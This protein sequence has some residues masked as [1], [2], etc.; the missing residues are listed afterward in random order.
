M[1]HPY[2]SAAYAEV[3]REAA[4]PLWVPAWGAHVL[5]RDIAGGGRDAMG[6]YPLTAFGPGADLRAGLDMLR[7]QGL[8]SVGLVPDPATA[9]VDIE[10]V[11]GLCVPFKTHLLVDYG[12]EVRFSKHHRYE[13]KKALRDVSVQTVTLV[14]HLD[15][16]RGLYAALTERH[17]IGGM[18]AFSP[19]AFERMAEVENLTAVAA[20]AEGAIVSMHLWITDPASGH[21]YSLL[22]A[23][24]AEG[25]RRSAAYAVYDA[26]IRLFA[27]LKTLNLGAGAGLATDDDG[28]TRFKKGFANAEA[29]AVF[30]GAILDEA[31]YAALS[32]GVTTTATP[33]PAYRF[34]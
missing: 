28:L 25:Y 3:F 11:F 4:R 19:E 17:E 9:P 15:A 8:V 10:A 29:Q 14:D 6:V 33:F 31:R 1:T 20:F 2:A 26:S 16:W 21:G 24:S 18:T 22:A 27:G 7:A 30:C 34:A 12:R 32:G 13:V 5:T 23:S